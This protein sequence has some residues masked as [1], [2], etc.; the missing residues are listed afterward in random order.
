MPGL[1]RN[2]T[3]APE[4]KFL[5]LRRDGTKPEW[6]Y[7]VLGARDPAA[8]AALRAYAKTARTLAFDPAYVA[9]VERLADEFADYRLGHGEGNPDGPPH[10]EDDPDV[11][12]AMRGATFRVEARVDGD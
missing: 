9:D 12:A 5:V 8:A 2:G 1:W 3:A 11:V 7:F 4:G 10:R 6:P